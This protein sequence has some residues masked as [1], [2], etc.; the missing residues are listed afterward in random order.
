M[1]IGSIN[2]ELK[3]IGSEVIPADEKY[4]YSRFPAYVKLK[5]Q[6]L[7]R[8]NKRYFLRFGQSAYLQI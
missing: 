2:G 7:T 6:Y 5:T 3:S 8:K 1:N 4:P